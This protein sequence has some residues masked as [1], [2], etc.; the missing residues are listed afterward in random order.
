[1]KIRKILYSFS[2]VFL[3]WLIFE[4]P[5]NYFEIP[6]YGKYS[7]NTAHTLTNAKIWYEEGPLNVNFA[8]ILSFK[9]IQYKNLDQNLHVRHIGGLTFPQKINEYL[10]EIYISYPPGYIFPLYFDS[11]F[12][13]EMPDEKSVFRIN[14]ILFLLLLFSL[15]Y[16]INSIIKC[17]EIFSGILLFSSLISIST[18]YFFQTFLSY[19]SLGAIYFSLFLLSYFNNYRFISLLIIIIGL[20]TDYIFFFLVITLFAVEFY[21]NRR[22]TSYQV[23]LFFISFFAFFIFLFQL[24][25]LNVLDH[26]WWKFKFRIGIED[27]L[28]GGQLVKDLSKLSFIKFI[29]FY[30]YNLLKIISPFIFI[31]SFLLFF[32]RKKINNSEFYIL[33]LSFFPPFFYTLLLQSS[34]IHEYETLKFIPFFVI[35]STLVIKYCHINKIFLLSSLFIINSLVTLYFLPSYY[36][37]SKS[38]IGQHL[39]NLSIKEYTNKDDIIFQFEKPVSIWNN[40]LEFPISPYLWW[41]DNAYRERNVNRINNFNE[42]K[43]SLSRFNVNYA[44]VIL[45]SKDNDHLKFLPSSSIVETLYNNDGNKILVI[46]VLSAD[47]K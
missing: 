35:S 42:L 47:K 46:D 15:Y 13:N 45:V 37:Y 20:L 27:T 6:L 3:L 19:N 25:S 44:R 39:T 26:L 41:S 31:F 24:Y 7:G 10:R 38:Y 8:S 17:S 16:T 28:V 18:I 5:R 9:S 11:L 14:D 34:S 4:I 40:N 12:F 43:D 1:M 30:C 29:L 23:W 33:I 22:F 2:V 21:Q 36:Q 32:L